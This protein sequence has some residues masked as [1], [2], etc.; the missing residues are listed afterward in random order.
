MEYYNK[1]LNTLWLVLNIR[2]LTHCCCPTG[3][4]ITGSCQYCNFLHSRAIASFGLGN[5]NLTGALVY[6]KTG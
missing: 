1:M 3:Y 4:D 5:V 6:E 2:N